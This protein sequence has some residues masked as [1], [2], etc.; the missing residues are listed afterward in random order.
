V[1]LEDVTIDL[2]VESFITGEYRAAEEVPVTLSGCGAAAAL[3]TGSPYLSRW[4]K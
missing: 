2:E 4:R 1:R 3:T